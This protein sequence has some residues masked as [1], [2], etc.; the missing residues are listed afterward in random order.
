[1]QINLHLD[2]QSLP[3][4]SF[5]VTKSK[6][7]CLQNQPNKPLKFPSNT[8]S[9]T[10]KTYLTFQ[11]QS[12]FQILLQI[13]VFHLVQVVFAADDVPKQ[14]MLSFSS[15]CVKMLRL[16][17]AHFI[18]IKKIVCQIKPEVIK[19]NHSCIC[20]TKEYKIH[21]NKIKFLAMHVNRTGVFN[22]LFKDVWLYLKQFF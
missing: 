6:I 17:K 14:Q 20:C 5:K 1:M 16:H 18:A 21:N 19:Q 9:S 4:C 10:D 15:P 2:G 8:R 7:R 12:C 11:C 22:F 13:F 3:D